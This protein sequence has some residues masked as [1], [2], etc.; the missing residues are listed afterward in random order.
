VAGPQFLQNVATS[1]LAI[2]LPSIAASLHVSP[3]QLDLVVTAYVLSIALFLPA[4]AW[5]ADRFGAK[6]M[7]C[8]S[9]LLF[10]GGSSLC[11]L[12]TTTGMLVAFR[13]L[14]GFGAALMIPV[15]RLILLRT[16][17]QSE[18]VSAMVWYTM[19]PVIGRLS[20]PLIGGIIVSLV[21]W[22]GIFFV[23][24]PFGVLAIVLAILFLPSDRA[25]HSAPKF[26]FAGFLL[27]AF[28]LSALLG[29]G[30]A[31]GKNYGQDV[32]AFTVGG[33]GL[34]ALA[35]YVARNL[36]QEH[37]IIDLRILKAPT[38]RTNVL[39]AAPLRIAIAGMPFVLPLM[40]QIGFGLSPLVAGQFAAA[41][42]FGSLCVRFGIK[43]AMHY[44]DTR[45]MLIV[46][47][48]LTALIFAS[49]ALFT[50]D[51]PH[52]AI[53]AALFAGGLTSSV[54]MV[55]LNTLGFA[56]IPP[57]RTSHAASLLAMAQQLFAGIG[58]TIAA[59]LLATF[60][61]WRGG[62]RA[63]LAQQ[64]FATAFLVLG[65]IVLVSV[66][67]FVRL[68]PERDEPDPAADLETQP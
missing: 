67:L 46:A 33:A 40:F 12:A 54:C 57:N 45:G 32:A 60:A 31:L 14:Q 52:L 34:A 23:N 9:I 62:N 13:I 63:A 36:R 66:A 8:V 19:P 49:Y 48:L 27:L 53:F 20:G 17:P 59:F 55:A 64:D 28:G 41:S 43:P 4:S 44:L 6:R 35:V 11:G 38:Y 50:R 5:L 51:T 39:G 42:A 22:Q 61:A 7:F 10:C 18:M 3:L 15:G 56:E 68:A 26:D 58:V 2:A 65:A 16:V 21:A 24:I 1:S 37:P 25:Q 47:S 30:E 29:A